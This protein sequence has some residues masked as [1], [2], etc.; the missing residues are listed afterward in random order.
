MPR[1]T[2]RDEEIDGGRAVI[3]DVD[4]VISDG[5]HR[6]HFLSGKQKKWGAF[7][8]ASPGDAPLLPAITLLDLV[9]LETAVVLLT[10]RPETIH[11]ETVAWLNEFDVRWDL[12]VMRS[13]RDHG[14]SPDIKRL[15]VEELRAAG[16]ELVL[17]LDDDRR[18]I[19]MFEEEDIPALYV[20]SGYYEA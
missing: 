17:A 20:H 6:Q 16:F 15:A 19:S 10:A 9:D 13:R 11:D 2:W 18:N 3:I 14:H 12:L 1:W 5:E 4:G 7:F 8:A